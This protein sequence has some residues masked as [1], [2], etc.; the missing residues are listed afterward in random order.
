MDFVYEH[1]EEATQV[2]DRDGQAVARC[3]VPLASQV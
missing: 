2:I 3:A 1:N